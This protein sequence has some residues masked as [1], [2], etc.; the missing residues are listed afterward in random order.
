MA[1]IDKAKWENFK[2]KLIQL[3]G[4]LIME[5]DETT[6]KYVIS[7]GRLAFWV[8][9]IPAIYIW[10]YG[11]GKL[12]DGVD[13]RDIAD[14]HLTVLTLLLGYNLGTKI[15]NTIKILMGKGS[16]DFPP[17]YPPPYPPEVGPVDENLR[18]DPNLK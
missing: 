9:F 15:T 7:L 6:G 16:S 5:R 14:N 13:T 1:E 18:G 12:I 11:G 3:L 4:G 8:T 10:I 17:P 2:L